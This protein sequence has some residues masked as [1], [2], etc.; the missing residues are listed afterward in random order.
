MEQTETESLLFNKV[1][2]QIL[3]TLK[4][5]NGS[6]GKR[7][8]A[9]K[10]GTDYTHVIKIAGRLDKGGLVLS[11][12]NSEVSSVKLTEKGKRIADHLVQ[13]ENVFRGVEIMQ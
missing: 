5:N 8:L 3:T 10:I 2:V 13:I 6:M 7:K 12:T 9:D 11:D 4:K 1:P